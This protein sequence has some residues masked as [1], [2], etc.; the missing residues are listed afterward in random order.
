MNEKKLTEVLAKLTHDT[1]LFG[2]FGKGYPTSLY[3]AYCRVGSQ[4]YCFSLGCSPSADPIEYQRTIRCSARVAC[5][6]TSLDG[7]CDYAVWTDKPALDALHKR[8]R[9]IREDQR[10]Q[11]LLQQP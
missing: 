6:W 10:F 7:L 5:L 11:P 3:K 4:W 1:E 8:A 9:K 2:L